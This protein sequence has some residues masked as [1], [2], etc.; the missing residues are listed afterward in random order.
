MY[1]HL[2][3]ILQRT[4]ANPNVILPQ[5]GLSPL[6]IAVGNES[7][8]F[9]EEV[10][11]LFLQHGGNPNA[12]STGGHTPIHIAAAWGRENIINLLLVNGGDP[13]LFNE[14]NKNAFHLAYEGKHWNVIELLNRFRAL[15]TGKDD[16]LHQKMF[17]LTLATQT[18]QYV[19]NNNVI[20]SSIDGERYKSFTVGYLH[21]MSRVC[22]GNN[23]QIQ[24]K[25]T[26]TLNRSTDRGDRR[27][28]EIDM[29]KKHLPSTGIIQPTGVEK[30][31]KDQL[32]EELK[33]FHIN[34]KKSEVFMYDPEQEKENL[35]KSLELNNS[36]DGDEKLLQ[37]Q[38]KDNKN[39]TEKLTNRSSSIKFK[40]R[41][42]LVHEASI[43][44]DS[45]HCN[46]PNTSQEN[47][48]LKTLDC[49]NYSRKNIS[50]D[51]KQSIISDDLTQLENIITDDSLHLHDYMTEDLSVDGDKSTS[52]PRN[53]NIKRH[54]L[55]CDQ[56]KRNFV[57]PTNKII[58]VLTE[59]E[60]IA[61]QSCCRYFDQSDYL[62][63]DEDLPLL[64][65]PEINT[66]ETPPNEE[67]RNVKKLKPE[68]PKNLCDRSSNSSSSSSGSFVSVTEEYKYSDVEEGI[69]LS[70]LRSENGNSSKHSDDEGTEGTSMTSNSSSIPSSLDYDTD[71]LRK[72]LKDRGFLPGPIV[73]STKKLYLR[74]LVRLEKKPM[75]ISTDARVYSPELQHTLLGFKWQNW[76]TEYL[77]LEKEVS[78]QFSQP[79]PERRWREGNVKSS[80]TYLL[81]DP[82]ITNNL[83]CRIETFDK[84]EVWSVFLSAIFYVGKGKRSRPY[85]HLYQ[86][87]KVWNKETVETADKKVQHIIDI[88]KADM[89]VI[90]LHIF[91]NVIPVEAYTREAAMIDAICLKNLKNARC[92]EY[93]GIAS[94]WTSHQKRMLGTFLLYR[95][96]LIFLQEGERQLRPGDIG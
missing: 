30:S 80:F 25:G 31:L 48:I 29:Q 17:E 42:D 18:N 79:E 74:K 32:I 24:R 22:G 26:S 52:L 49:I 94:T 96:M 66:F 15:D 75:E 20:D 95:A 85:S 1:D 88:W 41:T 11:R 3:T 67:T 62:T 73:P 83:P 40:E 81:L 35:K 37:L 76:L 13:W 19:Q 21:P 43:D 50:F 59:E 56:S 4:A 86:A 60:W 34:S 69:V 12:R 39:K 57:P 68:R 93:Y 10:T 27:I 46:I 28:K 82:R 70:S 14:D 33:S 90:C 38:E 2:K 58:D 36:G 61:S 92:G 78:E 23:I 91:Q 64:I 6:H 87:F 77:K 44:S 16:D 47:Y 54:D 9:A 5:L 55:L 51:C 45:V 63:C 71:I 53:V 84:L 65:S 8:V 89:G 7:E 72:R